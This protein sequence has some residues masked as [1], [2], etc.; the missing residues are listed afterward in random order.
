MYTCL[1][2][3][4]T[5]EGTVIVQPFNS[6]KLTSGIAGSLKQEFRELQ[7]LAEITKMHWEETISLKVTGITRSELI[8]S[9]R[10]WEGERYILA[11]MHSAL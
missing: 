2:H 4:S 7:L 3:G 10:K 8:H 6:D 11:T 5:L 1:S 9:F